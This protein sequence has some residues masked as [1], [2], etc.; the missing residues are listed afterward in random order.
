MAGA[1][2]A[3]PVR[4]RPNLLF[5]MTDSW[6]G[7]ALPSAGDPNLS[8][9]NLQ[10]LA[11]Q[12]V[13]CSR[14]YTSYPVC[15]P[16][17]AATLTGKLPH[18]AG[19]RRNHSLLP[20]EQKTMSAAMKAAGYRTGYIG[21]WHLDGAENPGFVPPE[22]RRGF[23]D[24][25]AFNVD[26]RHYDSVYFRDDPVP[27]QTS[28]FEPD[29]Q[30][31]LAIEFL[32]KDRGRPFYLY[33]S[34]VAPHAPLTPP[35]R[36]AAAY[37]PARLQLRSNVPKTAEAEARKDLAG[38]YGLC[39][40]VSDNIGRLLKELDERSAAE[41]TIV[42]FTSDHGHTL[43]SH[44]VDGIDSPFE[45]SARIPLIVR[46]PRRFRAG[47]TYGGLISNIDF[48]PTLMSLCGVP[49]PQGMQGTN[50]ATRLTGSG[51][52][53]D[54]IYAEG[55]LGQEYEWRMVVS[56][57]YKLVVDAKLRPT[58]LFDLVRDPDEQD[59]LVGKPSLDS[60]TER[61]QGLR[62]RWASRTGDIAG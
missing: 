18:A 9:P 48:A 25:F 56:G 27:V 14:V 8:A 30:T 40:A 4:R 15:C 6:R 19:V 35:Q 10:R 41:D 23:D 38:Y 13:Y 16:S 58:H 52:S 42:V 3:A 11:E 7:Q 46:Y 37:D 39:S 55:G 62:R 31:D 44:G 43:W 26:H 53:A 5:I 34:F 60:V 24:W 21:K 57:R 20:L 50:F 12:G 2:F 59:D 28:G 32:R 22:R 36:Y 51:G 1:A 47:T 45:E 49:S 17:R 29:V 54:S 33:L 61:L